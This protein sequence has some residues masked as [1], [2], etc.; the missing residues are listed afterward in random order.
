MMENYT[1]KLKV[2]KVLWEFP[3][4]GWI[5]FNTDGASRG[6]PGRSSI[7]FCMRNELGDVVYARGKEVHETTN[8]V[9]EAMA[10]LEALRYCSQHH[11]SHI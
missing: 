8:T 2:H 4:D 5:K 10:I 3:M 7:G 6:N 9:A 1:L 11:I